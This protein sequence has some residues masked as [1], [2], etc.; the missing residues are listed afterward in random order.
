MRKHL[1]VILAI[2]LLWGSSCDYETPIVSQTS[3]QSKITLTDIDHDPVV[4]DLLSKIQNKVAN[5]RVSSIEITDAFFKYSDPDSGVLNY[6]F[7]LPDESPDYFENLVLSQ[8]E[9]GFYGFIY[10][11]I[12]DE[13]YT[14][15]APFKG[16]LKLYNL[17]N[18]LMQEFS[19]P[20]TQDSIIANGK[21]QIMDRCVKSVTQS[22]VTSY[23]VRTVTDYP[24]HCQYDRK[25]E[26]G[27]VC[28][29]SV[30]MGWCD[31]MNPGISPAVGG[32]YVGAGSDTHSGG[33]SGST[34]TPAKKP[35]VIIPDDD[36]IYDKVKSPCLVA[37]IKTLVNKDLTN[38]INKAVLS[39]FGTN[40]NMN[41]Y[42]EED[43]GLGKKPGTTRVTNEK[44]PFNVTIYLNPN[45]IDSSSEYMTAVIYHEAI[46]AYLD[47]NKED[48]DKLVQHVMIA[49]EYIEWLSGALNEVFPLLSTKS[50][51][52]L[53]LSGLGD[54]MRNNPIYFESLVQSYGFANVEE[55]TSIIE[56]YRNGIKGSTCN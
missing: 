27:T 1:S 29:V 4:K 3:N 42:F 56:A 5:G 47:A 43:A 36:I 24:C 14:S 41:L 45:F 16:A 6:T 51:S 28:T 18:E 8:Y 38:N 25:V 10:R 39:I 55:V 46:H 48:R 40:P 50:A 33:A 9:D 21:V 34:K 32:T 53:A 23:E 31:D 13:D 52:A 15:N 49:H 20:S 19:I 44:N 17:N 2:L 37:T 7:R 11:Y 12:P 26:T 35:V 30:N 22:C 54:V